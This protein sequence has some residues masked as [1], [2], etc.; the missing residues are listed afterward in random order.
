MGHLSTVV[1]WAVRVLETVGR[2]RPQRWCSQACR[3]AG[4]EERRAAKSGAIAIEYVV[5]P[6]RTITIDE[7]VAAVLGSPTACRNVLRQL[8][9]RAEDGELDA[10]KWSSVSDE[11]VRLRTP[12]SRRPDGWFS[13]R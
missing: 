12:P 2:G 10:A 1:D 5:K 11:L 8:R 4:C 7:H 3:R 9:A 13:S 6:A